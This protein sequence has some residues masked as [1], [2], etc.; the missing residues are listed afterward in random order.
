M[1]IKFYDAII[2]GK[3]NKISCWIDERLVTFFKSFGFNSLVGL[4]LNPDNDKELE[5][6]REEV[7]DNED[8]LRNDCLTM[9]ACAQLLLSYYIGK[10]IVKEEFAETILD[11]LIF[12]FVVCNQNHP[13]GIVPV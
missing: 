12:P 7:S 6:P 13:E 4:A 3:K 9:E 5:L 8:A 10:D 1:M 11:A 2:V